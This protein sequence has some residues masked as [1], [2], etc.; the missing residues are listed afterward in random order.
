MT[1]SFDPDS[2]RQN[3]P[4]LEREVDGL[5]AVYFD[6][7]AG[8]QVP[9]IVIDAMSAYL[10]G[11]N[12]NHGGH[13][14]TS[15]ESDAMLA[16]AHRAAADFMGAADADLVAFGANMTTL[17]FA[18]SRALAKTWTPGDEVIERRSAPAARRRAGDE[19]RPGRELGRA[20]GLRVARQRPGRARRAGVHA[21]VPRG[22]A[23][24]A[25]WSPPAGAGSTSSASAS[26]APGALENRSAAGC[27]LSEAPA[28][29]ALATP[30]AAWAAPGACARPYLWGRPIP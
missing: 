1:T 30:A 14:L 29:A 25:A 3:F 6:G 26:S 15:R 24:A 23:P 13:F 27:R 9:R 2:C 28:P 11:R 5:P 20:L 4:A 22:R 8:S 18:L 17:T 12:A 10:G 7:P 16:E 21:V 19:H